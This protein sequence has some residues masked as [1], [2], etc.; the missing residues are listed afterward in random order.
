MSISRGNIKTQYKLKSTS[1]KA[2]LYQ[3]RGF[4]VRPSKFSYP[5]KRMAQTKETGYVDTAVTGAMDTT[6]TI[7]LINT[8]SQGTSVQQRV[9][10]KV[11]LRGLQI[12]GNMVNSGAAA[13]ANDVAYMIVY[14]KRPSGALPSIS[15]I[16]VSANANSMNNDNNAGRF[17]ILK[18]VDAVLLGRTDAI[19]NVQDTSMLGE[20][21]Y[22][23]LKGIPTTYKSATTGAIADIEEGALYY[24]CVGVNTAVSTAAAQHNF[25][26]RLR[27]VDI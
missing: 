21:C 6:G 8:V 18:R 14:D 16:L 23:D 7:A 5:M 20:D 9:G 4:V 12:R 3:G 15:D 27:F 2:S 19:A 22:L 1:G 24:V 11:S 25:F 13:V 10:K 26:C 17:K